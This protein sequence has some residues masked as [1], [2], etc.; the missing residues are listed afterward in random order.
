MLFRI[1]LA[2]V[3]VALALAGCQ[4]ATPVEKPEPDT[5]PKFSA[6]VADRTYKA[7]RVIE[8]L[9]L[10]KASGGNRGLSY[11]LGRDLPPG[12]SFDSGTRTL[13]GKPLL[14][15]DANETVYRMSYRVADKDNNTSSRDTDT[16]HFTI[17]IQPRTTLERVVSSVAVETQ[18]AGSSTGHCRSR[19]AAPPSPFREATPSWP[20]ARS[21]WTWFPRPAPR[22]IRCS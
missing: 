1:S 5:A 18:S 13:S 12:L 15:D 17:T 16:L 2:A 10:P 3:G 14:E 21:F 22:S 19:A 11:S 7:L 9:V 8:P 6:S 20:V 4:G